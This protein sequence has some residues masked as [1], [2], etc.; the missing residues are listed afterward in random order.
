MKVQVAAA[1]LSFAGSASAWTALPA[2]AS[3]SRLVTRMVATPQKVAA[4]EAPPAVES[5]SG[6]RPDSWRSR[7]AYQ[8][9]EY[10]DPAKLAD[11]EGILARQS[12]LVFAGE[13]SYIR[14]LVH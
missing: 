12:P 1:A 11:A 10:N 13:V 7:T 8:M 5:A 4:P 2:T 3:R 9:P 14:S 6:W